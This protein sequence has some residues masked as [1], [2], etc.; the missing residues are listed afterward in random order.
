MTNPPFFA[1]DISE[2]T[3]SSISTKLRAQ[4]AALGFAPTPEL[5]LRLAL[6]KIAEL[7]RDTSRAF[8]HHSKVTL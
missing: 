5:L 7:E 8:S 2:D 1:Q 4:L 6:I 3:I